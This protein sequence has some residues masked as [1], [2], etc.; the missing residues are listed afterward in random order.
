MFKTLHSQLF[1]RLAP[2]P[3]GRRVQFIL[4]PQIQPWHPSSTLTH[5]A[6]LAVALLAPAKFISYAT[7][8]FE[9]QTEYFDVSV[10]NETRN[11]TYRRL[12]KLAKESVGLDEEEVYRMLAIPDA[13]AE[14]GSLNVGNRVTDDLKVL[15]RMAR[16]VGVH[17]S[18]T[19]YLDGV[20][21]GEISSGWSG[22]Q[23]VEWLGMKVVPKEGEGVL[24]E[25]GKMGASHT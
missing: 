6:A 10:V 19:V 2:S 1:P 4:R 15:V 7:A 21:V 22:D 16:G 11:Q 24:N 17:V 14:D 20:E 8:L 5:E 9:H 25:G 18:P 13:P 3:I 23:W 12:A